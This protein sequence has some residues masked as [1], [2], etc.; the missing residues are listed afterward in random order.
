MREN[1]NNISIISKKSDKKGDSNTELLHLSSILK[2]TE[3]KD[4]VNIK[5]VRASRAIERI[6]KRNKSQRDTTPNLDA[7]VME[8]LG[9]F[10]N[11]AFK[12][13]A[14]Y[15]QSFKIMEIA[16]NLEKKMSKIEPENNDKIEEKKEDNKDGEEPRP[17]CVIDIISNKPI[18][19]KKKKRNKVSFI[20]E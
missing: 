17:S 16:K 9:N 10:Q 13:K 1:N 15:R 7:G 11:K 19:T 2:K 20:I 12:N 14:K 4:D 18:N 5:A 3:R 6:R 8:A